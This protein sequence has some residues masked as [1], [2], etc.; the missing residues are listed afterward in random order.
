MHNRIYSELNGKRKEKTK[1]KDESDIDSKANMKTKS[2]RAAQN[3]KKKR[4]KVENGTTK[5]H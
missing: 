4:I 3:M 5:P 1:T 2:L